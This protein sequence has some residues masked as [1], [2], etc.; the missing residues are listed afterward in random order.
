MDREERE[1]KRRVLQV[2]QEKRRNFIMERENTIKRNEE[3]NYNRLLERQHQSQMLHGLGAKKT[4]HTP[5]IP[6]NPISLEYH[7]NPRGDRQAYFDQ[8]QQINRMVRAHNLQTHGTS[9][10]NL[11]NG[12]ASLHV[13]NLLPPVAQEEFKTKLSNFYSRY[14]IDP[15]ENIK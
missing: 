7:D 9:G 5:G 6:V 8:K 10:Y 11:I 15:N 3:E 13:Q 12:K 1:N 4:A 14:R 2:N